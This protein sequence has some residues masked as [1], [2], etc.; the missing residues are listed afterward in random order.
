MTIYYGETGVPVGEVMVDGGS[1]MIIDPSYV[2]GYDGLWRDE[3]NAVTNIRDSMF[4]PFMRG[5]SQ[6]MADWHM[7]VASCAGYGDGSY[8]VTADTHPDGRVSA[9]H[10]DFGDTPRGWGHSRCPACGR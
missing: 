10:I 8:P 2:W 3:I 6:N 1:L 9:L 7:A 5:G 4:G